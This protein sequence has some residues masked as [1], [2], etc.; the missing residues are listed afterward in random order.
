MAFVI[1]MDRQSEFAGDQKFGRREGVPVDLWNPLLEGRYTLIPD[2]DWRTDADGTLRKPAFAKMPD[3]VLVFM[4]PNTV[5]PPF[6]QM[7]EQRG[8][9]LSASPEPYSVEPSV[10][11]DCVTVSVV[12]H[13]QTT[14][15][16]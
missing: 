6:L 12:F 16:C 9:I 5:D 2:Y 4:L 13:Y 10:R 7:P 8:D 14:L 11:R 3:R 15:F 1:H